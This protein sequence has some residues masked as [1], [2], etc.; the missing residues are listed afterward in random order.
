MTVVLMGVGETWVAKEQV[1]VMKEEEEQE[2]SEEGRDLLF[3]AA[4]G[5]GWGCLGTKVLMP[6]APGLLKSVSLLSCWLLLLLSADQMMYSAFEEAVIT[7]EPGST[8]L[9]W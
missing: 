5:P 1:G 2:S 8:F 7:E 4:V 6:L 9:H 3:S